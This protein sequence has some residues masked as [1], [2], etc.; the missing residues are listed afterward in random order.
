MADKR[1]DVSVQLRNDTEANWLLVADTYIPLAG[2]A[3][4]TIDGEHEGQV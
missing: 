1:L 3:C 2:E 4:V